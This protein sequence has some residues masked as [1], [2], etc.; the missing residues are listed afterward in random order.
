MMA[1]AMNI[2]HCIKSI[3]VKKIIL[4]PLKLSGLGIIQLLS[5]ISCT[6]LFFFSP[7]L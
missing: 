2:V 4:I 7:S 6:P 1:A 5:L 3:E